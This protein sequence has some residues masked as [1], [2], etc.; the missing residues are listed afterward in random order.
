[1]KQVLHDLRTGTSEV[2]DVPASRASDGQL[3]IHTAITLVSS[4][5]ER[6]NE[7]RSLCSPRTLT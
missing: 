5:T 6:S 1:M 3:L 2:A 4:G 7:T